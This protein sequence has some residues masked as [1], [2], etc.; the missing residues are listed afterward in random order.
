MGQASSRSQRRG[1]QTGQDRGLDHHDGRTPRSEAEGAQWA[2]GA[3][4]G[5]TIHIFKITS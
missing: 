4:K 3:L 1:G 5:K 2:A